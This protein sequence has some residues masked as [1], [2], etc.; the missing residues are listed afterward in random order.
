MTPSILMKRDEIYALGACL[1]GNGHRFDLWLHSY[2]KELK[3]SYT[4]ALETTEGLQ[5]L[6]EHLLDLDARGE[7]FDTPEDDLLNL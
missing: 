5:W 1:F 2:S 6:E 7:L 3:G 4:I